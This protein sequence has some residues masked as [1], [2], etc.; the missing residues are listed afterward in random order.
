MLDADSW[1]AMVATGS[2]P[3][4]SWTLIVGMASVTCQQTIAGRQLV[5]WSTTAS[6]PLSAL[7]AEA[8]EHVQDTSRT[9]CCSRYRL[10]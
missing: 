5:G 4:K 7:I 8:R 1:Q 2:S 6:L 3:D 9:E 10:H